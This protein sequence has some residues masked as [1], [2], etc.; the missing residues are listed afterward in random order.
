MNM[1]NNY[2][3]M[4]KVIARGKE[5]GLFYGSFHYMVGTVLMLETGNQLYTISGFETVA[6]IAEEGKCEA[7]FNGCFNSMVITDAI[8]VVEC[9]EQAIKRIESKME[10]NK[11]IKNKNQ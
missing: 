10:K 8:E 5:S 6:D 4:K 2:F 7:R 11:E 3:G 9:T 1:I